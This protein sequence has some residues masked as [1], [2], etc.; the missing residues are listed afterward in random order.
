MPQENTQF[1]DRSVTRISDPKQ[2]AVVLLNDDFT[3]M[4]FVIEVLQKVF[5]MST[6]KAF[7]VMMNVHENG[8]GVAGIYPYDIAGSKVSKVERMASEEGAPLQV[9][10]EEV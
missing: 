5:F 2:Y 3:T 4:E 7:A 6:E 1:A 8:R 9:I 10:M